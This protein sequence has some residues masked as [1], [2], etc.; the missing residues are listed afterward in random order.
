MH[1][2]DFGSAADWAQA[3]SSTIVLFFIYQQ[4]RQTNT[5]MIQNDDQERYRRSWEFVKLYREEL[6]EFEKRLEQLNCDFNPLTYE[7]S[8]PEFCAYV[9][10]FFRP[11]KHLFILLNQMV[12]R[13]E[14]D[15][16]ML[17]GYLEDEFNKFVEIGIRHYGPAEFKQEVGSKINLLV[18]LWGAQIKS[19]ALL[20]TSTTTSTSPSATTAG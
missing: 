1:H 8:S 18:T 10:N 5:Q 11:R 14:V 12:M 13:Q 3:I 16:R 7:Q 19:K 17:F 4:M 9:L 15:E 6:R 20:F 2:V